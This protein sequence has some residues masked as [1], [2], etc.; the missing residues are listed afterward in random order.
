MWYNIG[1]IRSGVIRMKR[2][3]LEKFRVALLKERARII[4]IIKRRYEELIEWDSD[5]QETLSSFLINPI[6]VSCSCYRREVDAELI[7]RINFMLHQIEDALV[8]IEDKT[9]GVCIACGRQISLR[10][11]KAVPYATYCI[12]CQKQFEKSKAGIN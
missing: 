3:G 8:R 5:V 10:R 2:E 1:G 11:L 4:E 7:D 9:F 6:E 12:R